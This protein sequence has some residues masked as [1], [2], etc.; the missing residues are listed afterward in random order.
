MEIMKILVIGKSILPKIINTIPKEYLIRQVKSPYIQYIYNIENTEIIVRCY[1]TLN[2]NSLRG[3]SFD[4]IYC[5]PTEYLDYVE[6][7][8]PLYFSNPKLE[9]R[10]ITKSRLK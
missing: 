4:I 1:N 3:Q 7:L 2:N 10:L 8:I 5:H 9:I 6:F